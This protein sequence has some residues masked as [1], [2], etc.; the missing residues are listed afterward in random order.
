[1]ETSVP[2]AP[3]SSGTDNLSCKTLAISLLLLGPAL[4]I[5]AALY[6]SGNVTF[7]HNYAMLRLTIK[8]LYDNSTSK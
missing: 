1:M 5:V 4:L 6:L 8:I 3:V 2:T 7:H